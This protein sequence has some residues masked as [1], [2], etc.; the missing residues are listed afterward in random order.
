MVEEPWISRL[1][2]A[3]RASLLVDLRQPAEIERLLGGPFYEVVSVAAT[4]VKE[5]PKDTPKGAPTASTNG[6]LPKRYIASCISILGRATKRSTCC[7]GT[8]PNERI[9]R[10][11][12]M[13]Q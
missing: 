4:P 1:L 12:W 6:S 5:V 10:N 3:G 11:A 13:S 9:S 7:R 8:P 2:E